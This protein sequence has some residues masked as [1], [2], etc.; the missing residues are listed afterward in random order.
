M[1][2]FGRKKF[3]ESTCTRQI[4]QTFPLSKFYAI[5]YHPPLDQKYG[6]HREA[7]ISKC[8]TS[9]NAT[10]ETHI[11]LFLAS[12]H[13]KRH[14]TTSRTPAELLLC[15]TPQSLISF[16]SVNLNKWKELLRTK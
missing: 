9:A 15:R 6:T 12:Y 10:L 7:S 8:K 3:D 11:T 2:N 14:T 13:N 4:C 1:Q 5:W 16:S